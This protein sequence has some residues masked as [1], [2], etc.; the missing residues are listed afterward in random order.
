MNINETIAEVLRLDAEATPAEAWQP[1]VVSGDAAQYGQPGSGLRLNTCASWA[2][3]PNSRNTMQARTDADLIACYRTAA[4]ALA[5]EVQR[6]QGEVRI[7]SDALVEMMEESRRVG[8]E[9]MRERAAEVC[10][11]LITR[12][13]VGAGAWGGGGW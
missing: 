11:Y 10:S 1:H 8:Q 13:R 9:A 7:D 3:G 12:A 2:T 4:P 6:L 5:R